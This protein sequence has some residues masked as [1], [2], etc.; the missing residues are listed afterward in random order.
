MIINRST[1]PTFLT[2]YSALAT[3][4]HYMY[5][6]IYIYIYYDS[7][8]L[9][10]CVCK[11]CQIIPLESLDRCI[12]LRWDAVTTISITNRVFE[13]SAGCIIPTRVK[14]RVKYIKWLMWFSYVQFTIRIVRQF[15]RETNSNMSIKFIRV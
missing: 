4:I 6:Y 3:C 11:S 12:I 5:I 10:C 15:Y 8:A 1:Q 9:A 14:L 2:F 7:V 13:K